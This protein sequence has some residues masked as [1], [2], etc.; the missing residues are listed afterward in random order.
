MKKLHTIITLLVVSNHILLAYIQRIQANITIHL[1]TLILCLNK[2]YIHF[3]IYH[4]VQIWQDKALLILQFF[5]QQTITSNTVSKILNLPSM[6]HVCS[7][8]SLVGG[9]HPSVARQV[10][11]VL[12]VTESIILSTRKEKKNTFKC[13]VWRRKQ[14]LTGFLGTD[15]ELFAGKTAANL[16][17]WIHANTVNTSRVQLDDVGLVV[18][19]GDVPG[20]VHV[21]PGVC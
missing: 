19:W 7:E 13:N 18:G 3:D 10:L 11:L 2:I 9:L 17:V 6:S 8:T 15:C 16:V 1:N 14:S 21:I 12:N 5:A 20:C 4:S